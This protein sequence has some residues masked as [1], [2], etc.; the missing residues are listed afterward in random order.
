MN[1]GLALESLKSG[2]KVYREG[3]N[4]KGMFLRLIPAGG[5][6]ILSSITE[7]HI[8]PLLPF[9][10]MKTADNCFVPWLASQTDI[11][12]EDWCAEPITISDEPTVCPEGKEDSIEVRKDSISLKSCFVCGCEQLVTENAKLKKEIGDFGF[13]NAI[14]RAEEPL[15][16]R[17]ADL[18][19]LLGL[20]DVAVEE[21]TAK[22]KTLEMLAGEY[23][24]LIRYM[25]C[26]GDFYDFQKTLKLAE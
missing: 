8:H 23:D 25:D 6:S 19:I 20:R 26:G 3:W 2:A 16:S 7:G 21:M 4:G 5:Y 17:I 24:K 9:I 10:G 15:K 11:L 13:F 18:E 12:A 1:F 22:I 14:K